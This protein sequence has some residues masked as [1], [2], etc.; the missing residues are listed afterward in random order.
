MVGTDIDTAGALQVAIEASPSGV[1]VVDPEG[2]IVLVNRGLERQFG[3][4]REEL[5]G[6]VVELLLPETLRPIQAVHRDGFVQ[7]PGSGPIAAGR[8]WTSPTVAARKRRMA[9]R[10]RSSTGT[11]DG[12]HASDRG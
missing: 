1:L 12:K 2:R 8:S 11:C 3:Y 5:V 7:A 9:P 6:Q 4:A 10:S